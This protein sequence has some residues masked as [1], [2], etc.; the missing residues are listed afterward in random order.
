MKT[1]DF[2]DLPFGDG[3]RIATFDVPRF[4]VEA[5][6]ARIRRRNPPATPWWRRYAR[7]WQSFEPAPEPSAQES[8]PAPLLYGLT[9]V[10]NED[11]VVYAT[12]RNLFLQGAD[13]VF[14][15]DDASD[16]DT[17]TEA[18]AAGATIIHDD[19]DGVFLER[20]R[21]D[22]ICQVIDEQTEN[23]ERPV[24]WIVVDADEFPRG[25][26]G[27]TIRDFVRE[28][29]PRVETVGSRVLE[30]YPSRLSAPKPRFHP[31]DELPNAHWHNHPA[32]PAGHWKHQMLLVRKPGELRFMPGRHTVAAPPDKKPVIESE[33]SLLMHHFPLRDRDRT[34]RK[35]LLSG[36]TSGRYTKSGDS[37][38][39]RR[40][41]SRLRVLDLSYQ[42]QYHLAPNSFPG[43]PTRGLPVRD[44]QDLVIPSEREVHHEV[45]APL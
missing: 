7:T 40:I 27:L 28:L 30:H 37:F 33:Q 4:V 14:V 10:W 29:P 3:P 2:S 19:S 17:V 18:E 31:I 25:P 45:G 12:V 36:S 5:A 9:S 15:I 8:S 16:D 6:F 34:E 1:P 38:L 20:R 22:R 35:L 41:D 24:W 26:N 23:A 11:D 44:W 39:M 21:N 42:E 43:E 13:K 32:C